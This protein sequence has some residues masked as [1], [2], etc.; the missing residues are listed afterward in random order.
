M[1]NCTSQNRQLECKYFKN[2][3]FE[4]SDSILNEKYVLIRKNNAQ[5]EQ[6]IDLNTNELKQRKNGNNRVMKII[7]SNDCE[8]KVMVDTTKSKYDNLDLWMISQGGLN[9][10]IIK[11]EK[12][13]ATIESSIGDFK[14][15]LIICKKK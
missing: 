7:W 4:F 14:T 13:C 10:K 1:V 8:Y 11:I 12:N 15:H 3:T 2:G 6:V 9:N 5:I